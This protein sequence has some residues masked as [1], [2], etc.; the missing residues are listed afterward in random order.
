MVDWQKWIRHRQVQEG[1]HSSRDYIRPTDMHS[2]LHIFLDH[3]YHDTDPMQN[4]H[5]IENHDLHNNN[6][7]KLNRVHLKWNFDARSF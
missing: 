2:H 1:L 5:M 7:H 6:L 3:F 4:N